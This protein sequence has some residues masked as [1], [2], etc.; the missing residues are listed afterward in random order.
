MSRITE[1]D[2][3]TCDGLS[4]AEKLIGKVLIHRITTT[5][6]A[7][8]KRTLTYG[9]IISETEAY[10]GVI[11]RAS[12]AYGG[13]RTARTETMY[14]R[15]GHSYIYL[16]YGIYNCMNVT[17][18]KEEIPEAVLIRS[19]MPYTVDSEVMYDEYSKV[20]RRKNIVPLSDSPAIRKRMLYSIANGPGKLCLSMKLDRRIN[21]LDLISGE[22]IDISG[23]MHEFY[24]EDHGFLPK[25][26]SCSPRIGIDY[27]GDDAK[28]P[29]RFIAESADGIPDF[30]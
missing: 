10:M 15:G 2:F 22:T 4:L 7:G 21:G 18:N 13:K 14:L 23:E 11:D 3:F 19:V 9:G 5:D 30:V 16:I 8:A 20:S 17:A 29:W 24:L 12:H 6:D 27:A 28:K 25:G 26:I 1:R